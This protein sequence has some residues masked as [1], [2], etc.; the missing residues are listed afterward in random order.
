[1][2]FSFAFSSVRDFAHSRF[3]PRGF[4]FSRFCLFAGL[5]SR[6]C[7]FAV[8]PFRGFVRSWFCLF[9]VLSAR[10]RPRCFVTSRFCP[11]TIYSIHVSGENAV[12]L[13]VA[14]INKQNVQMEFVRLNFDFLTI[15]NK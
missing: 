8:L 5:S 2:V 7:P 4:V 6:F 3:C 11:D 9:A 13:Q 10:F 1:M 14:E 12:F 15:I